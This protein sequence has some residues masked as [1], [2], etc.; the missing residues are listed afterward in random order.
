MLPSVSSKSLSLTC[1]FSNLPS[2]PSKHI[3]NGVHFI[4]KRKKKKEKRKKAVH[5][6][7]HSHALQRVHE[8]R[9]AQKILEAAHSLTHDGERRRRRK[10][11]IETRFSRSRHERWF[12]HQFGAPPHRFL[13]APGRGGA[14]HRFLRR[15]PRFRSRS[16]FRFRNLLCDLLG[17]FRVSVRGL[18]WI[19]RIAFVVAFRRRV[20]HV[21]GA[22]GSDGGAWECWVLI[23]LDLN[24]LSSC[25]GLEKKLGI[26]LRKKKEKI[27][28]SWD[29]ELE[30]GKERIV[31]SFWIFGPRVNDLTYWLYFSAKE[32]HHF[33]ESGRCV[34]NFNYVFLGL[35]GSFECTV[36][37]TVRFKVKISK[38]NRKSSL[39]LLSV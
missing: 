5:R 15:R 12:G 37:G 30:G 35:S 8:E 19:L 38:S 21:G 2:P 20:F 32:M 10:V 1:S 18:S 25:L 27:K 16:R 22:W 4:W 23:G 26:V 31:I 17:I 6:K 3:P 28:W 36:I 34:C 33:D 11:G 29:L 7:S 39:C 24:T 14:L 13:D 9:E